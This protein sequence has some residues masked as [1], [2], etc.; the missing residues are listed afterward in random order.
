[1]LERNDIRSQ[2]AILLGVDLIQIF[3]DGAHIRLSL[4]QAYAR[5]E[6]SDGQEIVD[7]SILDDYGIALSK[8]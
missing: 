7:C 2:A 8:G 5:F 4:S 6:A 3:L 1:L